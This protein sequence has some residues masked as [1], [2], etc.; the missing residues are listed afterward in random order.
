MSRVELKTTADS[1]CRRCNGTGMM[2]DVRHT[3]DWTHYRVVE[4]RCSCV[5]TVQVPV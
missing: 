1:D 2:Q 3:N 5:R 4:V